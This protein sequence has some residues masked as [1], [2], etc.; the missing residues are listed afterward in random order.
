MNMLEHLGRLFAY[1]DWANR[2]V[3][4][5]LKAAGTP[6]PRSLSF[7]AHILSVER[8]WLERLERQEQTFPAWPDF[9]LPQ[10]EAQAAELPRLWKVYLGRMKQADLAQPVTYKNAKGET[11]ANKKGDILLQVIMHSVYHRGQIA[12]NMRAAGHTPAYTDFIHGVRQGFV[13]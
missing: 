13:E 5:S 10:C 8:L 3:L 6:P 11:W 1:D 9:T 12:T 4:A 2:E 7:M